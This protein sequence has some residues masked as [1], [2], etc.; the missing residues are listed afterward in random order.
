MRMHA[1]RSTGGLDTGSLN[2]NSLSSP[3]CGEPQKGKGEAQAPPSLHEEKKPRKAR[4]EGGEKEGDEK[5]WPSKRGAG[6]KG[7]PSA[8][9]SSAF[10]RGSEGCGKSGQSREKERV[11]GEVK[12]N[13][14]GSM[15]GGSIP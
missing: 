5:G 6:E 9:T 4:G 1:K 2:S 14:G 7:V 11:L 12:A 15:R 13:I 3:K 10:L 8:E